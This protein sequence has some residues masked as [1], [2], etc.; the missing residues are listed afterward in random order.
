MDTGISEEEC[1]RMEEEEEKQE[2]AAARQR[3]CNVLLGLQHSF[4]QV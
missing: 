4:Q 3:G 1:S 2:E